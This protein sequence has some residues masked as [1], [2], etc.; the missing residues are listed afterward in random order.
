[1]TAPLLPGTTL[2]GKWRL[3][4]L[5]GEGGMG[6]V[7][8][9]TH[10]RNGLAVAVKVLF[11]EIARDEKVRKRFLQEGYAANRV[12]HKG[13]V[14]V[15]DDGTSSDGYSYLVMERLS[16]APLDA[17]ADRQGGRLSVDETLRYSTQALDVVAAA[18]AR[19]IVHR[20][21]KPE[22]VFICDDGTVKLL[23]FGIA[24][25]RVATTEARL[26]VTQAPLG[27]P[28]FMP[29]EQALAHWDRVGPHSDVY[30][31]GAMMFTL[32]TGQL[33]HEARTV[34]ELLVRVST[35]QARPVRALLPSLPAPIADV[36]DRALAFRPE[37]RFPDARAMRV[38]LGLAI[39]A[40]VANLE[41]ATS[42]VVAT[43]DTTVDSDGPTLEVRFDPRAFQNAAPFN[44]TAA[45]AGVPHTASPS[46]AGATLVSGAT[47]MHPHRSTT[48]PV[49]SG[50]ERQTRN[51]LT[52]GAAG[53]AAVALG[54]GAFFLFPRVGRDTS[55]SSAT[56]E[57]AA[58]TPRPDSAA[59]AGGASPTLTPSVAPVP[60]ASA[61]SSQPTVSPA[62]SARPT[63]LPKATASS[64]PRD[65]TP[66]PTGSPLDKFD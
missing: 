23:D 39:G 33:V 44:A 36:I 53:V 4:A 55:R 9:A 60:S 54:L 45:S 42:R 13:A 51:V 56:E 25:V 28:A 19:G 12:E 61:S 22:N 37:E 3:D 5:L 16:G 38:A 20:D 30:A 50:K 8:A 41:P 57:A 34:P 14:S 58:P 40:P 24:Q 35:Q 21:I 29:P 10:V 18:H 7:Y 46:P 15:L 49:S 31:L 6:A 48:A 64:R 66:K 26:T 27:T 43:G 17:V 59:S 62:A 1:M 47:P 11:P 65:P 2:D 52:L 32:L 63:T